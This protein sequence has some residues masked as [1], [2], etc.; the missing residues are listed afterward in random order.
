MKDST[1]TVPRK[2]KQRAILSCNDC[3]RRKLS[4]NR[5]LPCSRCTHGGIADA[6]AYGSGVW[7]PAGDDYEEENLANKRSNVSSNQSTVGAAEEGVLGHPLY[8]LQRMTTH[9][10]HEL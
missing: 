1:A 4:C 2:R 5:E 9:F 7:D 3:R 8:E 6:C 10:Y